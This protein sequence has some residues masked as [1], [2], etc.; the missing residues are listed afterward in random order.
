MRRSLAATT[1]ALL[2][3]LNATIGG[4]DDQFTYKYGSSQM[5]QFGVEDWDQVTC[6]DFEQCVSDARVRMKTSQ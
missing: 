6:D 2:L 3:S 4:N 5:K 1:V